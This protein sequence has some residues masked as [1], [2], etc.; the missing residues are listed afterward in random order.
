MSDELNFEYTV[1]KHY[2]H[3]GTFARAG[4]IQQLID[5][6][7]T[8]ETKE[9]YI[10]K[11]Q[12]MGLN[13]DEVVSLLQIAIISHVMMFIEDLAVIS[14]SISEG[15]IDYYVYLDKS[16]DDDLGRV[17]GKFYDE[18][19]SAPNETFQKLLSY[20]DLKNFEFAT[21]SEKEIIQ[22][23]MD[24][25]IERVKEFFI[26]ITFFRNNHI[27][28]F[29]RYKHAGFPIMLV[30]KI[31][32]IMQNDYSNYKFA[33]VGLTSRN[34]IDEEIVPIPYSSKAIDS[35]ENI[36]NDI[37]SFLGNMLHFKLICIE[38]K[39]SGLIPNTS[40]AF[41]ITLTDNEKKILDDAWKKFEEQYPHDSESRFE[42][43]MQTQT[44]ILRWYTDIDKSSTRVL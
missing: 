17:I 16:G 20:T 13:D 41:R 23:I 12:L 9:N 28:I 8:I 25:M 44:E 36:K 4:I 15:K 35:Y 43:K 3:K 1:L 29:R 30:Q 18:I 39:V 14:K 2:L 21:E 33:S 11:P 42:I 34:K 7:R 5:N 38:R 31:P 10:S 40:H 24:K 6:L 26:K 27:K 37:F 32:E 22:K 19:H